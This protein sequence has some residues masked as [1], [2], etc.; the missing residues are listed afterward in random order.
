MTQTGAFV[1][2]KSP[3]DQGTLCKATGLQT[4]LRAEGG[5][6]GFG[7]GQ[8]CGA[9]SCCGAEAVGR[10]GGRNLVSSWYH[11]LQLGLGCVSLGWVSPTCAVKSV[12]GAAGAEG[13]DWLL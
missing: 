2:K 10:E 4:S 9:A 11:R 3:C 5:Q 13:S 1:V 12:M 7:V 6:L 8:R